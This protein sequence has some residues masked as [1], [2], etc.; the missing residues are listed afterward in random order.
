MWWQNIDIG[1]NDAPTSLSIVVARL[2]SVN[3]Q[4]LVDCCKCLVVSATPKGIP[5]FTGR[6]MSAHPSIRLSVC[7]VDRQR[8]GHAAGLLLTGC[9]STSGSKYRSIAAGARALAAASVSAVIRGGST[10]TYCFVVKDDGRARDGVMSGLC[11]RRRRICRMTLQQLTGLRRR[12]PTTTTGQSSR[13]TTMSLTMTTTETRCIATSA[14][15]T[16]TT[17]TTTRAGV[18]P[19]APASQLPQREWQWWGGDVQTLWQRRPRRCTH[20]TRKL[21]STDS[22]CRRC[23]SVCACA[24]TI[25]ANYRGYR[26]RRQLAASQHQP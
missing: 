24:L 16:A 18:N 15:V 19:P 22:M 10:Q 1:V 5:W 6:I 21:A 8:Q 23:L 12:R 17:A 13:R 26:T 3:C 20:Y 4:S 7:P 2:I 25:Q 14:G 9:L 11:R